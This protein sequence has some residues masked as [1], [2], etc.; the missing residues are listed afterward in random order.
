MPNQPDGQPVRSWGTLI[1]GSDGTL[2]QIIK[3]DSDGNLFLC[4]FAKA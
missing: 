3:T 4:V 1:A 2:C